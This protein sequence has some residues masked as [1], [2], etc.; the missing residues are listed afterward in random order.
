MF[1]LDLFRCLHKH[2]VRYLLAGGLAMNLQS[3][4]QASGGFGYWV[5]D[6]QLEAYGRLTL[7]QRLCWL[8]E[9]RRFISLALS[10]ESR[11]RQDRLRRGL[12]ITG[13]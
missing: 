4:R 13:D 10:P 8:D 12:T 11:E 1:Y 5:S 6:E 3:D 2:K 7:L 9:A